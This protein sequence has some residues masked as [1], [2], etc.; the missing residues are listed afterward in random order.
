MAGEAAQPLAAAAVVVVLEVVASGACLTTGYPI[1]VRTRV[2]T[3]LA[4]HTM[5]SQLLSTLET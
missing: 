5:A 1:A 3:A 4:H 2:V